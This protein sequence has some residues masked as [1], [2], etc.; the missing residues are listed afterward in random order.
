VSDDGDRVRGAAS[1]ALLA[2]EERH[3]ALLQATVDAA[4]A[5][6]GAAAASVF[7]LDEAAGELVFEA[8]SGEGSAA[9]VGRRF[10][11]G[12]GI[13]GS[14]LATRQPLVADKLEGDPRFAREAAESTGYV[15]SSMMAVPLVMDDRPIGVLSVLDR[16]DRSRS[17][18]EEIELL[19]LFA[20]QAAIALELLITV[21]RASAAAK[22]EDEDLEAVTRVV[23]ALDALEGGRR[24]AGR[25]LLEALADVLKRS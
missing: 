19:G 13:A 4:R 7:L 25:R 20:D 9:L 15:P 16:R 23:A 14:V 21:R 10:P 2:S 5:I 6:F 3:H 18:L 22:G 12:T 8:V 24:D 17:A 11:A 1:S